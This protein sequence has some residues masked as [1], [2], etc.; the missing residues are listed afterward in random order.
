MANFP[1]SHIWLLATLVLT[2]AACGRP[3][4]SAPPETSTSGP[5]R[6]VS[7]EIG[8]YDIIELPLGSVPEPPVDTI[9]HPEF[10]DPASGAFVQV[11][12]VLEDPRE[13]PSRSTDGCIPTPS[14]GAQF[15]IPSHR[16]CGV[17]L[18]MLNTQLSQYT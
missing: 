13:F 9:F 18:K 17:D 10:Q 14:A 15:C 8:P 11:L 2:A 3:P 16:I 4:E 6:E 1:F 5:I 12:R 7:P